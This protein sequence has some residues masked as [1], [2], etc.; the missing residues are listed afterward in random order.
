MHL[1]F[2]DSDFSYTYLMEQQ[3][4]RSIIQELI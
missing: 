2:S 1:N 3:V 4:N